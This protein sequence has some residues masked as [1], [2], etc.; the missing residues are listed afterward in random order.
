MSIH[1]LQ[2]GFRVPGFFTEDNVNTISQIVTQTIGRKYSEKRVVVPNEDIVKFMQIVHEDRVESVAKM[3]ERV[4]IDLV[5]SFF[6]HIEQIEQANNWA[7]NRWNA[8]MY[9]P[10]LNMKNF[11]EPK[12]RG[13]RVGRSD[14][15]GAFRFHF[16]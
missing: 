9:D 15:K 13:D 3:N 16:T 5:R 4:V 1:T 14:G 12:L 6:S 7:D 10:S 8:Y 2:P 11:E